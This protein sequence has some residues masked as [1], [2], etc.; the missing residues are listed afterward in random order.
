LVS[1][2]Q[3]D[4]P[5]VRRTA[6]H[7]AALQRRQRSFRAPVTQRQPGGRDHRRAH[8]RGRIAMTA[9]P[10]PELDADTLE[11]VHALF[12]LVRAGDA[13]TLARL[14]HMGL[15]PNLRDAKGDSLLM[16]AAY[17]GHIHAVRLLLQHGADPELA[18][19]RG[20]TPLAA[21]AFKGDLELARTLLDHGAR[22]DTYPEGGRTA[23]M[24]AAMFDRVEVIDLL[25]QHGA[26]P[27]RCG[28]DGATAADLARAMG[29]S[30]A[31]ERLARLSAHPNAAAAQATAAG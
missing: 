12:A 24:L 3:Y 15:V 11:R 31:A 13:D 23:L 4:S 29:A 5:A 18:N 25:L 26:Q 27:G 17:H 22:V 10:R 19:D 7:L 8:S 9:S 20:Q 16:L 28:A 21:V 14:L 1:A 30:G 2:L 6:D